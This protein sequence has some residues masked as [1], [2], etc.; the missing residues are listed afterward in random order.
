MSCISHSSRLIRPTTV[1]WR[2][3]IITLHVIDIFLFS[4]NKTLVKSKYLRFWKAFWH[5]TSTIIVKYQLVLCWPHGVL[6]TTNKRNWV[7][8]SAHA[9]ARAHSRTHT[10]NT[11]HWNM[12]PTTNTHFLNYMGN[13]ICVLFWNAWLAVN[14]CLDIYVLTSFVSKHVLNVHIRSY[15]GLMQFHM[16]IT[17]EEHIWLPLVLWS[18]FHW[19]L[20]Q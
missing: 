12:Q 14:F 20:S 9:R 6:G 11:K 13:T 4:H 5:K 18:S 3:Q 19:I 2:L 15:S 7:T 8:L 16:C 17:M 1:T 10:H